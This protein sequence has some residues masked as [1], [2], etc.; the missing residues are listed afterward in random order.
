[1]AVGN[2]AVDMVLSPGFL[3][4]VNKVANYLHQQLGSLV[5]GHPAISKACAGRG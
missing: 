1:M 2:E 3:A 4:H 5:A